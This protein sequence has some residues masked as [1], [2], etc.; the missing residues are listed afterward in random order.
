[1]KG[2]LVDPIPNSPDKDC[3]I[4]QQTVK[5]ITYEILEV[6]G[7]MPMSRSLYCGPT[8]SVKIS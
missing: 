1:M 3:G 4:V 2:L 8:I 7:F 5:R 6:K